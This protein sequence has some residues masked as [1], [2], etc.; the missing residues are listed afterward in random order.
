MSERSYVGPSTEWDLRGGN[1]PN[2][3]EGDFSMASP[4]SEMDHLRE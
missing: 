2:S 3:T 1:A 4:I